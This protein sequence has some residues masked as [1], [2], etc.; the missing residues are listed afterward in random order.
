M[1]L[2]LP[3]IFHLICTVIFD[4]I[5]SLLIYLAIYITSKLEGIFCGSILEFGIICKALEIGVC[6]SI[7]I[8][9]GFFLGVQSSV[10]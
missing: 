6:I 10:E 9:S 8:I 2:L 5:A 1:S 4:L 7:L 3:I